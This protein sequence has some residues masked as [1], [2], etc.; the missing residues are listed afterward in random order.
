MPVKILFRLDVF[1][2]PVWVIFVG[3]RHTGSAI[4]GIPPYIIHERTSGF[5]QMKYKGVLSTFLNNKKYVLST[6]SLPY[7]QQR[8]VRTP[9]FPG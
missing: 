2:F 9:G 3:E 1:V 5:E 6:C 7:N 4:R 8:L